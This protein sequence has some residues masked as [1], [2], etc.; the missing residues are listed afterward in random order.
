MSHLYKSFEIKA[1]A[2]PPPT[3]Y[4]STYDREPDSYG[5]IIAKGAFDNTIKKRIESGHPW[6][7]CWNHDLDQIIG[8]VDP[9]QIKDEEKGPLMTAGF[10]KTEEKRTNCKRSKYTKSASYRSPQ[11][12]TRL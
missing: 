10:L 9:E 7:L 3:G 12:I 6:P 8:S 5:D 4:F 2:P 1:D 11:I